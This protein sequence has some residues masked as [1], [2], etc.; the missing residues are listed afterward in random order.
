[1]AV[2]NFTG[3]G[4]MYGLGIRL[5]YYLQWFSAIFAAW[6]ARSE[7]KGLRFSIDV[8][9]AASFLALIILTVRDVNSLEPV[10]VYIV[11]LLMFG[12]YLALVPI[13]IWRM[14]TGCDPFWDP[15]RYPIVNPGALAANLSFILLIGVLVYQ[16]WF[17]FARVPSLDKRNCQ[18][19]G[20]LF[21][22]VRLNS[23]ASVVVNALLYAFLGLI[24]LYLL[25]L[26]V[27]YMLG[28]DPDDGRR[29][30]SISR[31]DKDAH[32]NL[33]RNMEGWGKLLV[34]VIIMLA[35]EL[36]VQWN[37]IQGVNTLAGVGQTIPFV[38][39]LM[40]AVR[41]LYVYFYKQNAD[42]G[43]FYSGA[44]S[45][46]LSKRQ[47]PYVRTPIRHQRVHP[48]RSHHS[49]PEAPPPVHERAHARDG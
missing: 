49:D 37:E 46:Q 5:G 18:E 42:G 43:D 34:A 33:L 44:D 48:A 47:L 14:C 35:T 27:Q 22:Q 12:A 10:E 26:K 13:Y 45:G 15:T 4:D 30:R 8:F 11:L 39:G 7:V 23:K 41:I 31:R 2:C 24:C 6:M 25:A 40:S 28:V 1:M 17:W 19:Y 38:I 9:V 3:N 16:Y 36:T 32:I 29:R 20:F 21:G